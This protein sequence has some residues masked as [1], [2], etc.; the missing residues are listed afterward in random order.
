[1]KNRVKIV[2]AGFFQRG[3]YSEKSGKKMIEAGSTVFKY[4]LVWLN[5][6]AAVS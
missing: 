2:T 3:I 1:M 4:M 6:R 5:G